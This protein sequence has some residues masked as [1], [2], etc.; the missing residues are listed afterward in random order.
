MI[1]ALRRKALAVTM[2]AGATVTALDLLNLTPWITDEL[3][4]M[5]LIWAAGRLAR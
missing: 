1:A 2:T 5:A 4:M 3:A